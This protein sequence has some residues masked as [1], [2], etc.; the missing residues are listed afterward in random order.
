MRSH[1]KHLPAEERRAVTVETVIELAAEQNPSVITTAA[2]AKR[3]GL[4]QGALFRHFPNKDAI[5]KAVM[6]WV[7]KRLLSRVDKAVEGVS[8]P[9]AALEAMFMAHVTF[10]S[11]HPG[12]PRLLFGELQRAEVSPAKR[13]AQTLIHRYGERLHQLIEEGKAQGELDAALDVEAAAALFIG[14]I[15]GLVMQSLLAGDLKRMRD[16]AP[17]IFAIYCR[18]IRS[19]A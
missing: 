2:I 16:D 18:G 3:M 17:G 19:A 6:E 13:M 12:I 1:S 5:L 10:V 11:E 8:S 9:L 7:A 14:T 15:Q 4:T